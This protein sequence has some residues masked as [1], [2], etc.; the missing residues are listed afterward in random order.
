MTLAELAAALGCRL[1]GDGTLEIV[2][3][4]ALDEAG[5]GDVSFFANARYADALR[6]TRASAV[7]AADDV[8]V[9]TA[10]LRSDQPYVAFAHAL[11]L[12]HP[13]PRPQPGVHPMAAVDASA[14][15]GD[16]VSVGPF[17]SVGAR[18]VVGARTILQ[19]HAVIGDE[20]II[21]EDCHVH[22]HVSIRERVRIGHR[23]IIQ[24]GAVIG[25]DGFGFAP[26][27]AGGFLKVPQVGSVVVGDDVE[28]GA[29]AAI[30]RPPV[31]ATVIG[32]GTK[33]DNLVQ[34]AHGVEIGR[35]T[36]LASQVGIAGSTTIGSRVMLAGQVGVAGH[37][38]I[39]DGVR[40]TAQ[41]GIPHS[42]D[43]GAFV[44]GYPAI[45]N[46]DWL[47]ASALFR[48]LPQMRQL[49]NDILH[50]VTALEKRSS[51]G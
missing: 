36:I 30:D 5:P 19:A 14:T 18:A 27:A 13:A 47:K 15:L 29:L 8:D 2:R 31:G 17:V 39:G 49:L 43:A 26:Q 48:R 51:D 21:G 24:N 1:D 50:R 11:A 22:A 37:L 4:S 42:L 44:S 3:V 32:P 12:L 20:A 25:S 41:T 45:P 40:A 33:I 6:A 9:P 35:D 23:V 46:R 16:A 38:S 7:I 28:I 10:A 34:I